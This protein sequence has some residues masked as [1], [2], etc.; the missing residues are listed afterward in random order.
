MDV[1]PQGELHQ[2]QESISQPDGS[3]TSLNTTYERN[4]APLSYF[5]HNELSCI[6]RKRERSDYLRSLH[7]RLPWNLALAY[8]NWCSLRF[9]KI[10]YKQVLEWNL[11]LLHAADCLDIKQNRILRAN[12]CAPNIRL[13]A[14]VVYK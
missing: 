11:L 4:C 13:E 7:P 10:W 2:R 1:A 14:T 8:W 5:C 3:W 12:I 6:K 9:H